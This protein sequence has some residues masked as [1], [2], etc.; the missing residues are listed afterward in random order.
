MPIYFL[1]HSDPELQLPAEQWDWFQSYQDC[2]FHFKNPLFLQHQT[3]NCQPDQLAN[4]MVVQ[5]F[6]RS[7]LSHQL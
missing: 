4:G 2:G 6:G 7:A 1:P 3:C 5:Q